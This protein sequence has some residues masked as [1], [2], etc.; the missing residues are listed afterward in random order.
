VNVK[1]DIRRLCSEENLGIV[2]AFLDLR[3]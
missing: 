2:H 3:I 1:R